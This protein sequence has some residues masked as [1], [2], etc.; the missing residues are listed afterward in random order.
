MNM[1][2]RLLC[3]AFGHD[4]L[5]INRYSVPDVDSPEAAIQAIEEGELLPSCS[6][7]GC[8]RCGAWEESS[9]HSESA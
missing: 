6:V 9:H 8:C 1:F 4:W 7:R 2:R 3:L 5:E